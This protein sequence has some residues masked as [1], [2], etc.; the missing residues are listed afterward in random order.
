MACLRSDAG[1]HILTATKVASSSSAA[2]TL[3]GEDVAKAQGA[4]DLTTSSENHG[5]GCPGIYFQESSYPSSPVLGFG[6]RE[7][8]GR[9]FSSRWSEGSLQSIPLL[10]TVRKP[11][12]EVSQHSR[13]FIKPGFPWIAEDQE[14][15]LPRPWAISVADTCPAPTLLR[16]HSISH[17]DRLSVSPRR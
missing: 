7:E 12:K 8:G 9:R 17:L 3:L 16:S 2:I 6:I 11:Q 10:K 13:I 4:Q 1:T 5:P 14:P 15:S